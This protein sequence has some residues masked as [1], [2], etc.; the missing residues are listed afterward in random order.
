MSQTRSTVIVVIGCL[1]AGFLAGYLAFKPRTETTNTTAPAAAATSDIPDEHAFDQLEIRGHRWGPHPTP[2]ANDNL[3]AY[4]KSTALLNLSLFHNGGKTKCIVHEPSTALDYDTGFFPDFIATHPVVSS[5]YRWVIGLYP[6]ICREKMRDGTIR[7]RVSIF[8]IPT[9]RNIDTVNHRYD[10]L[11]YDSIKNT[12][13]FDI[14]YK[15]DPARI[16]PNTALANRI[17]LYGDQFIYDLGTI[18]P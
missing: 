16:K 18:F 10:I 7:P 1:A 6:E 9:M 5:N 13:G 4:R 12:P 3:D 17:K 8:M 11:D 15:T 2:G 14:Y